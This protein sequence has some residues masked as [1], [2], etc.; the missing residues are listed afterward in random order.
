MDS[1]AAPTSVVET[2]RRNVNRGIATLA[3]LMGAGVEVAS[4]GCTVFDSQGE[5]YLSCGGYGVF[6]LG[7]RHPSVVDAVKA[8]LDRHPLAS[9][10]LL[11]A[12]LCS[13]AAALAAV[14]PPGLEY[15]CFTNSGTEAVELG[16]KLARLNGKH[17]L[18]A[19]E[20]GFHGKTMGSLSVTGRERYRAPFVPLL[21]GVDFVQFGDAAALEDALGRCSEYACVLLEPVQ[22]E[23]GV[24]VPP[25]GY[26]RDVR[27]I[28]ERLGALLILDEIQ[29]GLGRVGEWWAAD[30]EAVVPDVLLAGKGLSG[31][32]IPVGAVLAS[33]TIYSPLNRDPYLHTSTF[34]GNPLAAVAAEAAISA[35]IR[36]RVPERA[37]DLGERMIRDLR[38]ILGPYADL[39]AEIRG[40]GLLIG[41]EFVGDYL[42]ADF[43]TELL[44][45]R[46]L[47]SYCLNAERVV[48]LTPPVSL[49][50][51]ELTWLYEAVE[52]AASTLRSR[53][54]SSGRG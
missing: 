34:G 10:V 51:S 5:A 27:G 42:A 41:I 13:A 39:V 40:L 6:I 36:E 30:R 29:T 19:M 46:V 14:A 24:R 21:P 50:D 28:C 4:E 1:R 33:S 48:R 18:I 17:R 26:L 32:V 3:E 44:S 45:R 22:G 16:I 11:S 53:Y 25:D 38:V 9:R 23:G 20:G 15:V 35:M 2:Y 7:H 43:M 12:E 47:V 54:F 52:S 37:R 8:Q 49:S 31:G